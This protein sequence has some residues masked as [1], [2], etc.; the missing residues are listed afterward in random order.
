MDLAHAADAHLNW[1]LKLRGA[2]S[3]QEKLDADTI[4][5]DNCCDLGRWLSTEAKAAH[6]LKAEYQALVSKHHMFHREA[7]KVAQ[8]INARQYAEATKALEAGSNYASASSAVGVAIK[9][10]QKVSK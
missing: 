2:I 5:R 3:N 4:A 9:A 10:M 1:K 8:M 6:G 7:G